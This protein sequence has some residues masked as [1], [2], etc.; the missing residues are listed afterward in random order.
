M[1]SQKLNLFFCFISLF[2]LNSCSTDSASENLA[3]SSSTKATTDESYSSDHVLPSGCSGFWDCVGYGAYLTGADIIGAGAG[4]VGSAGAAAAVGV[5]TAGTGA[6]VVLVGA[7]VVCGA[8]AS[9][10]A[11]VSVDYMQ[12]YD[13]GVVIGP[14]DLDLLPQEYYEF[15]NIGIEHNKVI[16]NVYH[17]GNDVST[18]Y[19]EKN[20]S[21]EELEV[22]NHPIVI[23]TQK[24]LKIL[25]TKYAND[26]NYKSFVDDLYNQDRLTLHVKEDLTAF[27]DDYF[28]AKDFNEVEQI[29]NDYTAEVLNESNYTLTE[30]RALIGSFRVA[31][32]SPFYFVNK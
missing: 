10:G 9:Y 8:G 29:I 14:L 31:S 22:V 4:I 26:H 15:E 5:P 18:Y 32:Q 25:S 19:D 16:Y 21:P 27:L 1:H 23:N 11:A 17:L 28:N 30:K 3:T 20:L 6:V 24:A 13:Q 7:G 2:L 12:P